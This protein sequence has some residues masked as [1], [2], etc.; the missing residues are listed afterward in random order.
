MLKLK[1]IKNIDPKVLVN[2]YLSYFMEAN[3]NY[4][5]YSYGN[6]SNSFEQ[7]YKDLFNQHTKFI[8]DSIKHEESA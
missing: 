3:L 5:I 6:T 8:L 7:E 1:L 4:F 2:E